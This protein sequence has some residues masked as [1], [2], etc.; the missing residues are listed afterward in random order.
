FNIIAGKI[1]KLPVKMTM[2]NGSEDCLTTYT[3]TS[4]STKYVAVNSA[5]QVKGVKTGSATVTLTAGNGD[6]VTCK[7]V[8]RAA[9]RKVVLDK[10]SLT[11]GVGMDSGL[12]VRV[13]YSS[14][15]Y[16]NYSRED[17]PGVGTFRSVDPSIVEIDPATGVMK[18]VSKGTT[19]VGFETLN[20]KYATCRVTVVDAPTS[21]EL[22]RTEMSVGELLTASLSV[23]FNE[24]E[25]GWIKYSSSDETI[26]TVDGSGKVTGV[27]AGEATITALTLNGVKAE[28]LVHVVHAP[29]SVELNMDSSNMAIGGKIALE[30]ICT[31]QG[32]GDCLAALTWKT[33]NSK[34]ATVTADGVV[35]GVRAGSATIR[36]VAQNGEYADCTVVVR[37]KPTKVQFAA[38]S[39]SVGVGQK[40]NVPAKV[41]FSG[42]SCDFSIND[43]SYARISVDDTTVARIDPATGDVIGVDVGRTYIRLTTYNGK[44]AACGIVVAPGPEWIS[45]SHAILTMSEGETQSMNCELSPGS[46][47]RLTYTSSNPG[48]VSVSGAD[49]N[50][51]LTAHAQGSATITAVSANGR[52]T[53]CEVTVMAKPDRIEFAR[54]SISVGLEDTA[55]LPEVTVT[56][57][58][59]ECSQI[60]AYEIEGTAVAMVTPGYVTGVEP[61]TAIVRARIGDLYAECTVVVLPK[62]TIVSV[63]PERSAMAV[64]DSMMLK[65]EMDA[66][67]GYF[68]TVENEDILTVSE[69]GEVT[70]LNPGSTKITVE[71]YNGCTGSCEITVLPVAHWVKLD[72]ESVKIAEGAAFVLNASI[73]ENTLGSLIWFSSDETIAKVDNT[74]VITALKAGKA[75]VYVRVDGFDEAFDICEV[76]VLA[77]PE[78]IQLSAETLRLRNGTSAQLTAEFVRSDAAECY[79]AMVFES[80][81]GNVAAVDGNGVIT[82]KAAG[83]AV[84]TVSLDSDSAVQ[85]ACE[86]TVYE[87]RVGFASDSIVMSVGETCALNV[88]LPAGEDQFSLMNSGGSV[89]KV[90]ASSRTVTALAAGTATITAVNGGDTATC[91]ITVTEKPESIVIPAEM[92][93]AVGKSFALNAKLLPEGTA[94][95]LTYTSTNEA[96]AKVSADGIVELTGVGEAVIRAANFDA[97][98]TA[99]CVVKAVH[100]PQ[101]IRFGELSDIVIAV[102]DSYVLETPVIHNENG[103]CEAE[104]TLV[105]S[106]PDVVSVTAEGGRYVIRALKQGIATL[107]LKTD[108][109]RTAMHTV[110]VEEVPESIAFEQATIRMAAGERFAPV[111]RGSNGAVVAAEL[112]SSDD[113]VAAVDE[114]GVLTAVAEGEATIMAVARSFPELSALVR[115]EV[116]KA[117]EVMAINAGSGMLALG[118]QIH[119]TAE[120]AD[121]TASASV[122]YVSGDESILRTGSNGSVLAVGEGEATITATAFGGAQASC[123]L[124]VMKAPTEMHVSHASITACVRDQ[125]QLSAVFADDTEFANLSYE[126][127]DADVANVS[128]SGLVTFAG[129]GET[130]IRVLTFNGL[131]AEIPVT[132]CDTPSSVA[133]GLADAVILKGD[134]AKLNIVFDQGAGYYTLTSS[135]P[136]IVSI[137]EDAVVT[138]LE[139]GSAVI[140]LEMPALRLKAACTVRVVNALEGIEMTV[141]KT[142][143]E[144]HEQI[145]PIYSL[146]PDNAIGTGLV[147]FSSSDDSVAKVDPVTGMVTGEAYG[148][149]V[150][151][152]STG[153]G[154]TDAVEINVLGG[155]RRMLVAYYFGETGDPGYLPFAYNNGYSMTQ[156]FSAATVE[157]QQYD[158]AG[159]YSNA[160]RSTLF[161]AIESH[162]ADATDD[163]VSIL[164]I[165][166]H[167]SGSYGPTGEYAFSLDNTHH[168]MASELM[169]RLERIKGRVILIMD[170]CYS[171]GIIDCNKSRLDAQDGRIS[172]LASSH[173]NTNSCYWNVSQK[174][175]SV[176]FFTHA[177]LQGIGFNEAQGIGGDRGWFRTD[178]GPADDAGNGDGL[179]TVS[180]LFSYAKSTTLAN[181]AKYKG[182]PEFH[183][184]PAQT[185]QSY[186]GEMNK[187][188]VLFSR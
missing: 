13:Y 85:A 76:T 8:V 26:A 47:T 126:S 43:S 130:V 113:Q 29:D 112:T 7:V 139:T 166:A 188:L 95:R 42:G 68:F 77:K 153:D 182:R 186:I 87:S 160:S 104:Y 147:T 127:D 67:G 157:G 123:T 106:T 41:F 17:A 155:K 175:T 69:D 165:C 23:K 146:K 161:G 90:N 171:G 44:K 134:S 131:E 173:R 152:A 179:V 9:P 178:G 27:K 14:S 109:G 159:P 74:G 103:D 15:K 55:R 34:V 137:G 1:I 31:Y 135:K 136:G 97:S 181:L 120:F 64:G 71:T 72:V 102:G 149:A 10:S 154:K 66:A 52:K 89:V 36:A 168:V 119:L 124:K 81:D 53:S 144:L 143:L 183:G 141:E 80:S 162:F 140:S 122:T 117:P 2:E 38:A 78:S 75:S 111:L 48:V 4:S 37:N 40:V 88:S 128:A 138:A 110:L 125:V 170:S 133:F 150:I 132:V 51:I 92:K 184:N 79:G 164:Y 6:V 185:P 50:C 115:I 145:Q 59:G 20:G 163:D 49:E 65:V 35:K 148:T 32:T 96:V 114:N 118:E 101:T 151:T 57:E 167:G 21:M 91:V 25:L 56:S 46:I 16:F 28:C 176:D 93:L 177:L 84:I 108:N 98:L 86:V 58:S 22:S 3:L 19:T 129:T 169:S 116:V 45:F 61:G 100:A 62:P 156:T 70:A 12:A 174:L 54:N 99:E 63:I 83:T 60:V 107:R 5:G 142:T 33:S 39:V 73:P 187:D 82:A 94:A 18:A 158:I 180:E 105:V 24:G 121:G 11:L 30:A 172:I